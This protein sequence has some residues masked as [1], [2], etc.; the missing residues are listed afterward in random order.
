MN[1]ILG[2]AVVLIT[3][4]WLVKRR[5]AGALAAFFLLF[6]L[7]TRTLALV[8]VDLAGPVYAI[9]L[10]DEVGG[11]QSMPLFAC[12]VLA[13]LIPLALVF[14][15]A[16]LARLLPEMGANRPRHAM[17]GHF[18]FVAISV[19]L[20]A[21][22]GD[23]ITRGPIPLFAGIDRLEYSST[24]AGPLHPLVFDLG[25]LFATTLGM[26]LVY[27]RL[28]GGDFDFRF[29]FLYALFML[30]FGLTG[31]R[32]SAF[33]SF[34]SFFIIPLAALVAL[35]HLRR[36]AP[37]P[38]GRG[39]LASFLCSRAA[40]VAAVAV[41]LLGLL[42]LLV[43]NLVTVRGYEDPA[44]QFT[45]RSLVQPVQL[46]W[47]TWRDLSSRANDSAL[48]WDGAF[49]NPIDPTRNT[50]IQVLMI[51]N[52][53]DERASELLDNGQQYAGGYPEI[54]F[55]LLGPY[56]A[57]AS[58]MVFGFVIVLLLRSIV[59]AIAHGRFLTA[60]MATYVFFGFSLLYIGGMLNFL[61][62]WT[63]W[64]KCG[65]LAVVYVAERKFTG[66]SSVPTSSP[67]TPT[68]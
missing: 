24:M 41:F 38:Q 27:P 19:F 39:A 4:W 23:M 2:A 48:A 13:L 43:H 8:Y 51:K 34:T 45:Q 67:S 54:L 55:E 30:Y 37:P 26:L 36:L 14:R 46:W 1:T 35:R 56:M 44:E 66:V 63:F 9:E 21:L 7:I 40:L 17:T 64:A 47:T 68:T 49:L 50:S 12:A 62:V 18:A 10:D 65:V 42:T 60:F 11:G 53:G 59:V 58:A 32:F 31:N 29:L 15:P 22:F 25:F 3:L 20:I 61:L 52:L 16:R 6:S 5:S 33:Y 28:I 57:L